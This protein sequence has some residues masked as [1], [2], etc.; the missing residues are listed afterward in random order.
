MGHLDDLR[1][2]WVQQDDDR[3]ENAHTYRSSVESARDLQRSG[4]SGSS[5]KHISSSNDHQVVETLG[6]SLRC[7]G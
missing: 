4:R 2:A 5:R 6:E 3:L 7:D 1:W